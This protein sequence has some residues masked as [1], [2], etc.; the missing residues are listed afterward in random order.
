V[1]RGLLTIILFITCMPTTHFFLQAPLLLLIPCF[2]KCRMISNCDQEG[3]GRIVINT[4]SHLFLPLPWRDPISKTHWTMNHYNNILITSA[5][6]SVKR[7]SD[8]ISLHY[9]HRI[10]LQQWIILRRCQTPLPSSHQ[11]LNWNISHDKKDAIIFYIVNRQQ[12]DK[13]TFSLLLNHPQPS[14][15]MEYLV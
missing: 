5:V 3:P 13:S 4:L 11:L 1:C 6:R 9:M 15:S 12:A 7:T 8:F 2:P 14:Y 10:I